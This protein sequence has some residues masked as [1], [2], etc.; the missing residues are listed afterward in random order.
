MF[1]VFMMMELG[2]RYS[3]IGDYNAV[4]WPNIEKMKEEGT[5]MA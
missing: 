5:L 4:I 2:V 1:Y 3:R